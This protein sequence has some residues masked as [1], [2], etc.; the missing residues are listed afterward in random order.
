[1]DHTEALP[2]DGRRDGGDDTN[3][4]GGH[5]IEK[6]PPV[7]ELNEKL[8]AGQIQILVTKQRE[9]VSLDRINAVFV[10]NNR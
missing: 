1:M 6:V 3:G 2:D 8:W 9:A 5:D 4:D 10:L 7:A